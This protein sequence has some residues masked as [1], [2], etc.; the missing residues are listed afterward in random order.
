MATDLTA[1]LGGGG[2]GQ[3]AL[4]A[5]DFHTPMSTYS[6]YVSA[7]GV[8]LTLTPPSGYKVVITFLDN[9]NGRISVFIGGTLWGGAPITNENVNNGNSIPYLASTETI[10]FIKDPGTFAN[11]LTVK[12]FFAKA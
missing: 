9:G 6:A 10:Q 4:D 1:L 12:Y 5:T 3:E 11:A 8:A 7:S 2:G